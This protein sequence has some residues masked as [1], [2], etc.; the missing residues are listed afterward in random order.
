[1]WIIVDHELY[2]EMYC[3]VWFGFVRNV[4]VEYI[5]GKRIKVMEEQDEHC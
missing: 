1:M 2:N 3:M 5:S 4:F